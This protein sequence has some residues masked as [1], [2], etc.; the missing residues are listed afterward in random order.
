M[1]LWAKRGSSIAGIAISSWPV[2][3]SAGAGVVADLR[4]LA[5]AVNLGLPTRLRKRRAG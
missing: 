3:K 1:T 5:M 2:R 4:V